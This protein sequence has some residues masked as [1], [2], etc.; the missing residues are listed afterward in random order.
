MNCEKCGIAFSDKMLH[1]T[2]PKGQPD[3][4]WMCLEWIEKTEPEL[5]N[6]IKLDQGFPWMKDLEY[7]TTGS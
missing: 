7:I 2:K 5:G 1:R 3:G 4:G 6:N